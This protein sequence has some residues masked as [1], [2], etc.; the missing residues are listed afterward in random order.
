MTEQFKTLYTI[1]NDLGKAMKIK[2]NDYI[3]LDL[4]NRRIYVVESISIKFIDISTIT[5]LIMY[6]INIFNNTMYLYKYIKEIIKSDFDSMY[7]NIFV[8]GLG[9]LG[10]IDS[11]TMYDFIIMRSKILQK[12]NIMNYNLNNPVNIAISNIQEDEKFQYITTLKSSDGAEPYII[13]QRH[14]IT[15]FNGLI[16]LLKSDKVDIEIRDGK[17]MFSIVFIVR[18]KKYTVNMYMNCF[19]I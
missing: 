3:Y 16:P 7:D 11:I 17:H 1:L 18:K 4:I 5:E 9:V 19:Y 13:D 10:H 6:D 15:L 8:D 14:I 12:I 2:D